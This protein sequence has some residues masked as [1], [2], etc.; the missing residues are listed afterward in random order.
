MSLDLKKIIWFRLT[1]FWS[2]NI[3]WRLMIFRQ[4]LVFFSNFAGILYN[5]YSINIATGAF[6]GILTLEMCCPTLKTIKMMYYNP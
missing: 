6:Y 5:L 1:A 4:N 2:K 3:K